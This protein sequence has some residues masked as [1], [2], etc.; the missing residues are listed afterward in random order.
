M[1]VTRFG[2]GSGFRLGV[3]TFGAWAKIADGERRLFAESQHK[4]L[5]EEGDKLKNVGRDAVRKAK[6]RGAAR[7]ATAV[8]GNIFPKDARAMARKP[9]Y[10]IGTNASMPLDHLETGITIHAKGGGL[11][12]PIF[13]AAKFKQP[14]FAT[15]AGRLSRVIA[16]MR[17]KYGE[18]H[19]HTL[20]DGT[21]AYG[22]WSASRAGKMRFKPL[23]ILRKSVTIPKKHDMSNAIARAAE[24]FEARVAER[25]MQLF[26]AGRDQV[27]AR[28]SGGAAR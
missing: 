9:A 5:K 15:Q 1:T 20:R 14:H 28:A 12:I 3:E 25:T 26:L 10:L 13:E 7:L 18:L 2:D 8:R 16:A 17:Q 19:W 24:G 21:P 22:A 4:A 11:M 27:V 23:F 6:I